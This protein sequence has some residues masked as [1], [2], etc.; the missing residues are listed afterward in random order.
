ML[1]RLPSPP[2]LSYE[3]VDPPYALQPAHDAIQELLVQS[4]ARIEHIPPSELGKKR[5]REWGREE[6]QWSMDDGRGG[7]VAATGR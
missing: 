3:F 7:R 1:T 5:A 4:Y 6:G 2:K